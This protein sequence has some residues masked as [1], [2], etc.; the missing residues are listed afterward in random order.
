MRCRSG[1]STKIEVLSVA[2]LLAAAIR[3]IHDDR[4]VSELFQNFEMVS[5]HQ[6]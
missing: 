4:S 5:E 1:D 6:W 3:R 2:P